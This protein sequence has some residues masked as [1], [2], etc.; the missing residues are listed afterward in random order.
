MRIT[1]R[2]RINMKDVWGT[3]IIPARG[4]QNVNKTSSAVRMTTPTHCVSCQTERVSANRATCC[5]AARQL[6]S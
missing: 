3:P 6:L 5:A 4:G 2:L 1:M